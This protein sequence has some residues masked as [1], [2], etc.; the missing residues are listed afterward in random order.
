M[1]YSDTDELTRGA[2]TFMKSL[3]TIGVD[4]TVVV[5]VPQEEWPTIRRAA[6]QRLEPDNE[7]VVTFNG[8]TFMKSGVT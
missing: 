1:T 5:M 6:T 4:P 8:I 7:V 2:S 3:R